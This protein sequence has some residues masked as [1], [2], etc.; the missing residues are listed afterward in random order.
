MT[1]SPS[2]EAS[3]RGIAEL[4]A[5][6]LDLPLWSHP[7][8]AHR[9]PWLLQ[10]TTGRGAPDDA[11][12]DFG[13]FGQTPVGVAMER[14]RT[15]RRVTGMESVV[16][17]RQVHGARL[18]A[19]TSD[20]APGLTIVDGYDAHSC[21]RSGVLLTIS[22]ADCI[23]VF[24]L[25]DSERTVALIHAGWRGVAAG[26]VEGAIA[27]LFATSGV[28]PGKL[29]LHCGPA[30]C[31]DCYEVG[32]EVH[33]AVNPGGPRHYHAAP[34]DLRQAVVQR[35][36]RFG[37]DPDRITSSTL[38]TKC[39]LGEFFSHRGGSAGRQLGLLGIRQDG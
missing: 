3:P 14:W 15:L 28:E 9:F 35:A 7:E 23:P 16:H 25:A 11:R 1:T 27:H 19:W 21:D 20:P 29:W 31:G 37:L 39:Q 33:A 18:H 36:M 32:P 24:L 22:V 10:G 2:T 26:V 6:D 5:P 38:C 17:S 34:I 4:L 13:L 30:I 8:W 12:F